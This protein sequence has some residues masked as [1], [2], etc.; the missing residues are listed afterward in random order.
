MIG[1]VARLVSHQPSNSKVRGSIPSQVP[2]LPR[3]K[4]SRE[5]SPLRSNG[6]DILAK[7]DMISVNRFLKIV[8]FD[9]PM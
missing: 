6:T 3:C 9:L 2:K 7:F 1:G 5:T 8:R 4:S